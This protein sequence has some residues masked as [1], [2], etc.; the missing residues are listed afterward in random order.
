MASANAQNTKEVEITGPDYITDFADNYISATGVSSNGQYV[1]GAMVGG[2]GPAAFYDITGGIPAVML[3]PELEETFGVNIAGITYDNIVFVSENNIVYTYNITDGTKTYIKSPDEKL[4]LDVWDVNSDGM[5]IA[6]NLTDEMSEISIPMYGVRQADGTYKITTLEYDSK[7][8]FGTEG[9][10]TQAR[11]LTE[12]GNNVIGV[13]IDAR[14]MAPRLVVWEKQEDGTFK[15]TT[16]LD[17]IIYDTTVEKPGKKPEFEDYV[18]AD[19]ETDPELYEQQ[20]EEFNAAYT[21]YQEAFSAFTRNGSVLDVFKMHRGKRN[22]II[23]AGYNTEEGTYPVLYNC[24]T[25]KAESY[26]DCMGY[27]F[28]DLPGGGIITFDDATGLCSL[29]AISE[30]G[31]EMMFTEWLKEKTGVDLSSYYSV[32]MTNPMT[33]MVIEGVFPGLPFFSHDGKTLALSGLSGNFEYETGVYTFDRDIFAALATGIGVNMVNEV[34]FGKNAL[35]IGAGR[36]GTAEVYA[37]DGTLC[38]TF[39]INGTACFDGMLAAGAYIIKV[40]VEGAQP[41]SMKIIIK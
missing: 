22:N 34:T 27:A 2:E 18:T 3:D 21:A 35:N 9:Q 5:V 11:F 41:V 33:G 36:Q 29:N 32:E 13:Q 14:G 6:G 23:Y 28:E 8:I 30:D 26:P 31:T 39:A 1:F 7:D 37:M 12:D 40:S 38:D 17:D 24:D 15:F 10:F 19:K 25:D 16:P 20:R 4:G